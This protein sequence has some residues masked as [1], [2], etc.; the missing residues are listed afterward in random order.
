MQR[1]EEK[2]SLELAKVRAE[3]DHKTKVAENNTLDNKGIIEMTKMKL[4]ETVI[5]QKIKSSPC[6]FDTT[7][8]ALVTLT[9][10]GVSE[11]VMMVMIE[12]Q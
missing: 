3:E 1:V 8:E 6:R 7:P 4:P 10:S 2:A 11:K 12:K 5:M 9:K